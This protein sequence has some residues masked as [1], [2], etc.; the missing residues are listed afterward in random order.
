[1][2]AAIAVVGGGVCLVLGRARASTQ[3][4]RAHTLP[5]AQLLNMHASG[6]TG[7]AVQQRIYVCMED[8]GLFFPRPTDKLTPL[9]HV[10]PYPFGHTSLRQAERWGFH[11]PKLRKPE[12]ASTPIATYL[13]TKTAK[14]RAYYTK[15][16][17]GGT[18][19]RRSV[20]VPG[21]VRLTFPGAGCQFQAE[22]AVYK[23]R[24]EYLYLQNELRFLLI[25][26]S[27]AATSSPSVQDGLRAWRRCMA[28][29][30]FS[31]SS[32]KSART[33]YESRGNRPSAK[34]V[35]AATADVV[36]QHQAHLAARWYAAASVDERSALG[37]HAK[38]ARTWRRWSL[39]TRAPNGF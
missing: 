13:L 33:R 38:I 16:L 35:R 15:A 12:H 9:P 18:A 39:D 11:N 2:L 8:Q 31:T 5:L 32:P 21:Y 7:R 1:M 14:F 28:Q 30:H 10:T 6:A 17:R 29:H 3:A 24:A 22:Q 26:S 27:R 23:N 37:R 19:T 20:E 25:K 34:E 4:G 36:C